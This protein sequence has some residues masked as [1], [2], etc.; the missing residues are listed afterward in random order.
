VMLAVS[1]GLEET[2]SGDSTGTLRV[3][4]V[5]EYLFILNTKYHNLVGR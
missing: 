4:I 5:N 3:V 1:E 2:I